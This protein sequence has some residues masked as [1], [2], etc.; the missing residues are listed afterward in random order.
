MGGNP[1]KQKQEGG[2]FRQEKKGVNNKGMLPSNILIQVTRLS[3][4][5]KLWETVG[6]MLSYRTCGARKLAEAVT[7]EFSSFTD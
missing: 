2:K 6:N 3:S 7:N 4:S 1:R 5:E